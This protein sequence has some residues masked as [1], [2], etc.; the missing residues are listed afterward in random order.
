MLASQF[1]ASLRTIHLPAPSTPAACT[2]LGSD[3]SRWAPDSNYL[4]TRNVD[5]GP[6]ARYVPYRFDMETMKAEPLWPALPDSVP[7]FPDFSTQTLSNTL[8]P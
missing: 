5:R 4:I 7:D 8:Q 6:G 2:L 3:N 1:S